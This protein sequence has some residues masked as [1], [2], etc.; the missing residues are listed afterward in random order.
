M[1]SVRTMHRSGQA[2]TARETLRRTPPVRLGISRAI[3]IPSAFAKATA[4]QSFIVAERLQSVVR[5]I[6]AKAR[7]SDGGPGSRLA[8][9]HD[10]GSARISKVQGV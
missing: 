5:F 3:R 6:S 9:R 2:R 8:V 10:P 7:K 1:V 4:D